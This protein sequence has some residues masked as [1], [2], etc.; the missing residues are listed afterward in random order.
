MLRVESGSFGR[1]R[2]TSD[3]KYAFKRGDI[4]DREI[5][6]L[7]RLTGIPGIPSL[8]RYKKYY[9]VHSKD[10]FLSPEEDWHKGSLIMEDLTGKGFETLSDL[11]PSQYEGFDLSYLKTV[12]E[13]HLRGI[14][15]GDL[16][17]GNVMANPVTKEVGIVDFG[18]AISSY[19]CALIEA[20]RVIPSGRLSWYEG[21]S[22]Q[23]CPIYFFD[24]PKETQETLMENGKAIGRA[25][26]NAGLLD[27]FHKSP[28]GRTS[29]GD[30]NYIPFVRAF[31]ANI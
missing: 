13:M 28:S 9:G 23:N 11:S 21:H 27:S 10:G 2:L 6:S 25:L 14:S 20:L 12:K 7:E 24:L 5:T 15:H 3:K 1:V 17:Y 31:Y 16:H 4:S 18:L 29:K 19:R 26:S 8:Y 30:Y 22:Y